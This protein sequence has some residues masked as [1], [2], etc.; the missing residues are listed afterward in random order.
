M[1][2]ILGQIKAAHGPEGVVEDIQIQITISVIIEESGMRGK[3]RVIDSVFSGGFHKLG[4]AIFF[5]PLV[6]KKLIGAVIP[7]D[8][9]GVADINIQQ[10]IAIHINQADPGGP[11]M[12]SGYSCLPCHVVK[13]ET[14]LIQEQFIRLVIGDHI[15]IRQAVIVDVSDSYAAAVIIIAILKNVKIHLIGQPVFKFQTGVIIG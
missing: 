11:V 3:P 1:A 8:I 4:N 5:I 10:S 2:Q 14:S 6:E 9:S 12:C 13:S 7:F 15:H